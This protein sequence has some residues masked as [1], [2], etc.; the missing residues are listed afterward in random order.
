M[1]L[2]HCPAVGSI[3][4]C[5]FPSCFSTPEMVKTRPVV[6][7]S[8][9]IK[10]RE[11]LVSI[12]PLSTTPPNPA[13]AHHCQVPVHLL[14]KSLQATCT[15]CWAKCDL[16][17]T[18][19]LARLTLVQGKRNPKTGKRAYEQAKVDL[20]T[21]QDLRRCAAIGL[22]IGVELW[23]AATVTPAPAQSPVTPTAADPK[24]A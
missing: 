15:T 23:P 20:T 10:G 22:G 13:E 8:P 24:A 9:R 12:V 16:V 21:L 11:G 3:L 14:P 2:Q 5:E 6:V 1:A 7:L 19:S 4:M 17:Y 18:L